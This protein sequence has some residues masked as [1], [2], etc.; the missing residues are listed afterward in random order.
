MTQPLTRLLVPAILLLFLCLSSDALADSP[1]T[2]YGAEPVEGV[3][4]I[5]EDTISVDDGIIIDSLEIDNREIYDTSDPRYD[6]FIFRT[7]NR[8]HIV[9]KEVVIRRELLLAVG[10][11]FTAARAEETARNLRLN[12]RLVD[13]WIET[14]RLPNGH[15]LVRVVTIDQWSLL[16]GVEYSRDGNRSR[17]KLGFEERNLAGFNQL[18]SFDWVVQEGD[19]DYI[20]SR[21]RDYRFLGKPI[22]FSLEHNTDPRGEVSQFSLLRPFYSLD[23]KLFLSGTVARTGGRRDVYGLDENGLAVRTGY[24]KSKADQFELI[25]EY[26]VGSRNTKIG[27]GLW[28]TYHADKV[29]EVFGNGFTV[30]S[31]SIYHIPSVF[32]KAQ[33]T[34]FLRVRRISNFKLLEDFAISTGIEALAG[35]AFRPDFNDHLYDVLDVTTRFGDQFGHNLITAAHQQ[36]WWLDSGRQLRSRGISTLRYYN[37]SLSFLTIAARVRY[38]SDHF[39]ALDAPLRLGGTT[40]IR[41][42]DEFA[43]AGNRVGTANLETRWY[44]GLDFLSALIGGVLFADFGR[45]W[46]KGE[47]FTLNNLH[48]SVGAGL[49]ISLERATRSEII[50]IDCALLEDGTVQVAFG[51]GQYF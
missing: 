38:Q 14:E 2:V 4:V 34:Q 10:E 48:Y 41:G 39:E 1:V 44:P 12:C 49:R 18:L 15:L 31:D 27:G 6:N 7:A 43:L 45:T 17:L 16:G 25:G 19:D 13:A 47:S 42:Y 35:R 46:S 23:Q 40:G 32:L 33:H 3:S 11:S 22:M 36:T 37:N 28:Y 29:T 8:L 21:F 5:E 20:H 26:R 24:W 30:P 9:T 50:R 51:T